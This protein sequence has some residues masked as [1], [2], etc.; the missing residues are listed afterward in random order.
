M[1]IKKKIDMIEINSY[2]IVFD[3]H[4]VALRVS[5]SY[6]GISLCSGKK[7]ERVL[8]HCLTTAERI[9]VTKKPQR[10]GPRLMIDSSAHGGII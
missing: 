10:S 3:M 2:K 1:E 4:L 9:V 5:D 8:L 7:K 6:S